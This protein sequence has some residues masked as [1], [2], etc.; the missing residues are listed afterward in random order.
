MLQQKLADANA[1][2]AESTHFLANNLSKVS[3]YGNDPR[4]DSANAKETVS[5]IKFLSVPATNSTI[6]ENVRK[7]R[8]LGHATDGA[9]I[10]SSLLDAGMSADE[11][12]RVSRGIH[13]FNTIGPAAESAFR[14]PK[15]KSANREAEQ[16]F[17][18]LF[19]RFSAPLR[20]ENLP[21]TLQDIENRHQR[22][23]SERLNSRRQNDDALKQQ[24]MKRKYGNTGPGMN[25]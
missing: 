12:A 6:Y 14:D 25:G 15:T 1:K 20:P 10:M 21:G 22:S 24:E 8:D 16:R 18:G 13:Q 11:A 3:E 9:K 19:E 17:P 7:G 4:F 2:I 23:R 5:Q